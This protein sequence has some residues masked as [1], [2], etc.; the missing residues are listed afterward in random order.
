MCEAVRVSNEQKGFVPGET[1]HMDLIRQMHLVELQEYVD[2]MDKEGVVLLL[3]MEKAFD[4]QMLM[5]LPQTIHGGH[6]QRPQDAQMGGD[7]IQ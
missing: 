2:S 1:D 7:A 4:S 6:R 5:E 3:D